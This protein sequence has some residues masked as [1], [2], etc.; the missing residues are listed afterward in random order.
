MTWE[1]FARRIAPGIDATRTA[2]RSSTRLITVAWRLAIAFA[3]AMAGRSE[4]VIELINKIGSA[5]YGRWPGSFSSAYFRGGHGGGPPWR[6][7]PPVWP[8]TSCSGSLE[9]K[10]LLDVVERHRPRR[11]HGP[12]TAPQL[13]SAVA[14]P[15]SGPAWEKGRRGTASFSPGLFSSW[16]PAPPW[17]AASRA[18]GAGNRH[19]ARRPRP[20][21]S[22]PGCSHV[23]TG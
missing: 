8:A 7:L 21:V 3:M 2:A 20:G 9:G 12:G 4:T 5:F 11:D 1:D 19:S 6:G 22:L 18:P 16:P 14:E 17:S 15:E 23:I 10:R 13:G